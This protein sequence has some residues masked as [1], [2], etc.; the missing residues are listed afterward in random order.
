MMQIRNFSIAQVAG[1]VFAQVNSGAKKFDQTVTA[2]SFHV[3]S[4]TFVRNKPS[5][6][7]ILS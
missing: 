4:P 1:Q 2:S 3:V 7:S 5:N 6:F